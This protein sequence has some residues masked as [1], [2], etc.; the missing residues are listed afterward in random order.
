MDQPAKRALLDRL[1]APLL[2]LGAFCAYLVTLGPGA[3]PGA[4]AML[5]AQHSGLVPLGSPLYPL[6]HWLASVVSALPFGPLALRLNALSAAFGALSIGLLYDVVHRSIWTAIRPTSESAAV[7]PVAARLAGLGAALALAL[8]IPFWI[9]S[10]RFYQLTFHVF[11]LLAAARLFLAYIAAPTD[12]RALVFALLYGIGTA[13]STMFLVFAPVFAGAIALVMWRKEAFSVRAILAVLTA[14]PAAL[15]LYALA[16]WSFYG[17][18]GYVLREY[19]GFFEVIWFFWRDQY[20]EITRTLPRVGWLIVLLVTTVPWLTGLFVAVRSLNNEEDWTYYA[21][22]LVMTALTVGV[23]MNT[24]IAPWALV[25]FDRLLVIPYLVIAALHGYLVAYWYLLPRGWWR[26]T[27]RAGK[28]WLRK[29]LGTV[30]AACC[31]VPCVVAPFRNARVADARATR[32]IDTF[33]QDMVS[34]LGTRTWL[35]TDGQLDPQLEVAAH[36]LGREIRLLNLRATENPAYLNM[37]SKHLPTARLR[38]LARVG[39][40]PLL[41]EWMGS[42]P[43]ITELLAIQSAPDFWAGAGL[44]A[45]PD[46]LLFGGAVEISAEDLDR[47]LDEHKAFWDSIS[48]PAAAA[49]GAGAPLAGPYAAY[50]TRQVGRVANDLGVLMEDHDRPDHAFYCYETACKLDPENLSALMNQFVMVRNGY[51]TGHA[52][53]I[54]KELEALAGSKQPRYRFWSLARTYGYV[55]V[56]EAFAEL[57]WTWALSGRPGLAASGLRRA[58]ALTPKAGRGAVRQTLADIHLLQDQDE[59]SEALCYETLVEDPNNQR[60]LLVLGRISMRKGDLAKAR[61]FLARAAKAGIPRTTM[62]LEWA[63]LHIAA[64]D[65]AKARVTLEELVELEP[66]L[67]RAWGMLGAVMIH[68]NDVDGLP[69]CLER[70]TEIEGWR[71][72]LGSVLSGQLAVRQKDLDAALGHFENALAVRPGS[73]QALEWILRLDMLM[74]RRKA[75]HEHARRLLTLD[76]E[77]ALGHYVM[78]SLQLMRGE[79]ELAEDSLRRSIETRRTPDALNDLAWLLQETGA[80]DEAEGLARAAFAMNDRMFQALDTL[81]VI[82][83]QKKQFAEAED[84]LQDAIAMQP[85]ALAIHLHLAELY[86][87]QGDRG[88]AESVLESIWPERRRLN[89]TEQLELDEL[90]QKI[91]KM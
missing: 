16:A 49:V 83:T 89:V 65:S 48:I 22:H 87:M 57:G 77:N 13:E 10:N 80:Y 42:D 53:T 29:R 68:Q 51:K 14:V 56:P 35:V 5:I 2:A 70:I 72:Y 24:P 76:R 81:G 20:W 55:R 23:L 44:V 62:A 28:L 40:V 37:I 71:G 69:R 18:E 60:A 4:S 54:R 9:A 84:A 45:I 19:K 21:L 6:W 38:N 39:V 36:D 88:R 90:R 31:L 47:L 91:R 43:E 67:L 75:G 27:E 74:G 12:R 11:L 1:A 7:A 17:S 41:Q 73:K 59:E 30:L 50:C 63:A 33:A 26:G 46:R 79:H 78:G 32:F 25:G 58:L 34:T 66:G 8:S 15:M 3:Y 52:E 85:G 82:L 61:D 64:G 86:V